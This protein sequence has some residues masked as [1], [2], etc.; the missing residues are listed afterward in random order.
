M[1]R[2]RKAGK[3]KKLR[4]VTAILLSASAVLGVLLCVYLYP[5][6]REEMD[7]TLLELPTTPVPATLYAYRPS[8]RQD[9]AGDLH[10]APNST[11]SESR[12][13]IYVSYEEIPRALVD[14]FVAIEDKRFW[15]HDGVDALRTARACLQYLTGEASFGG[16]TI[17]QQLVKNL[18]GDDRHTAG[19]KLTEIFRALDLERHA[20]KSRILEAYLNIINLADGCYGVGAAAEHY[21]SKSVE[22]LTLAECATIA[23]I[24]NNPARYNPVTHPDE[25]RARRDLILREMEKQGYITAEERDAAIQA[26]SELRTSPVTEMATTASWYADMVVSDVIRDLRD[27]LGY[28]YEAAS[29]LVYRGGLTIETAMD[30]HL[31]AAVERYYA[32]LDHFPVG[33]DGRPQSAL[34]LID[35][36]TGDIL[37]VAGAVGK[38][39]ANRLQNYATDTRRPSGSCIKPLTVY[40]PALEQGLITWADLYEDSP[41]TAHHGTPWPANAD[42]L[43]RGTVTVG[44]AVARSLNPVAVRILEQVGTANALSFARDRLGMTGLLLPEGGKQN[45][46]TAAS[47]ALGQHSRGVTVR[48]LTA[49]YTVFTD[50]TYR[51]AVS[52][53]RVLDKDGRVILEN[54][55]VNQ[56]THAVLSP[57]TAAVM[58]KLLTTVTTAEEGTA[59]R[60]MTLTGIEVA[61]KTG[62]TQNNC[63]RWFVGYTPRLLAG[64]WMG[65]DYPA[66]MKGILGNPCVTI[67]NQVMETCEALYDASPKATTFPVPDTVV[68]VK[69]CPSSGK[70]RTPY[71]EDPASG[72]NAEEG[73]FLRGREPHALCDLHQEPAIHWVPENPADPDRIPLLPNDLIG[74]PGSGRNDSVPRPDEDRPRPFFGL[75]G[76]EKPRRKGNRPGR[77]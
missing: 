55:P 42:G 74:E 44:Q 28:T 51:P 6:A 61:G 47:M 12:P 27:R 72:C 49:A 9:R 59:T 34:I 21:F 16:S 75:F 77:P 31:Q 50:G 13:R 3:R 40:A 25:N 29:M 45:D 53:H 17:T 32:D 1:D 65:Y 71:C 68:K 4:T 33:N 58:T 22:E 67:W 73:W 60:Y 8:Q 30:E 57:E 10:P 36:T 24:T 62:T 43:Y 20:D 63:D 46:C 39:E 15:S 69:F 38:K 14:A 26:P 41:L 76:R 70:L 18:T 56:T 66:E 11:L 52:Y 5:Y 19:R 7:M 37:A 48:E 35:P 2:N 23:A 64:V 54:P